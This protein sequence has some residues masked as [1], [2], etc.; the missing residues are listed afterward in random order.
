MSA[1][2]LLMLIRLIPVLTCA[3]Q[4]E[5]HHDQC[6][7]QGQLQQAQQ[8]NC[9]AKGVRPLLQFAVSVYIDA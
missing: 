5:T 6:V 1:V 9:Q 4:I 7:L 8:R 3:Q 2:D